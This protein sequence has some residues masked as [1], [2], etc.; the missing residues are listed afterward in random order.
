MKRYLPLLTKNPTPDQI[1]QH[2]RRSD[3][4]RNYTYIILG[5][6]GPTGKSTLANALNIEGYITYEITEELLRAARI[7]GRMNA[8]I[9]NDALQYVIIVL[10]ES[11]R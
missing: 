1:F 6:P 11:V 8:F 10:N 5:R 2:I 4:S 3:P 7:D 9:I